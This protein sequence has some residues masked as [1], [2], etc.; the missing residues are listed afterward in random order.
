MEI[1]LATVKGRAVRGVV[2]LTGR[3]FLL[4]II[5]F[6]GFFLLTVFLGKEEIGLFFAI[7]E[8]VA[9]LGY[10]SD[11]GLAAA[12][13]QKKEKP[14]LKD[15]RSTFTIQQILVL[16]LV[17]LVFVLTPWFRNF[18]KIS[19]Q[20]IFLL[21][22]LTLSFFLA[23]LKTIPSVSLER[24]L[25]FDLLVVVEIVESLLFYGLAVLLAWK[26][27]GVVSYAWAVLA[28]GLVGVAL[29][30]TLSP[31]KMG[32]AFEGDSLRHLLK[33]GL[34]YQANSFLAVIKDRLMNV[35]LWKIIGATGVGILG[36]A[37][38]WAQMPLR[39]VMDS[40]MKVTF[41]AYSRMQENREELSKAI[42]KTLFFITLFIFPLLVGIFILAKPLVSLIPQYGKWEV[43]LVALYLFLVNSLWGAVTTPLTNALTAIGRIKVVFKLMVMWT[44]LTWIIYP[45]LAI[46]YGFN[47]VALG[48]AIVATSS[49]VAIY[50]AKKYIDFKFLPSVAKP[51]ISSVL[52]GILVFLLNPFL[53]KNLFG[54]GGLIVI[55]GGVYFGLI[56]LMA[57]R[58]FLNDTKKIFYAFKVR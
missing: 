57:G 36:W 21:W 35:F 32:F 3:T 31:W 19:Q 1:D 37:Q 4:Q 12:L 42:E 20:G 45:V 46:K 58:Q 53:S 40:V 43:A 33:F 48:A 30:Y 17:V 24:K 6:F 2:A 39:F 9:I 26:N 13:I 54:I 7:S 10:F 18:Y 16:T 51:I 23:S 8:L 14:S 55:G 5:S 28:R 50:I 41:P 47:G 29:I 15:I 34:P 44:V 38:K 56:S 11:I 52:M 22:A 25:R 27:F 49:V